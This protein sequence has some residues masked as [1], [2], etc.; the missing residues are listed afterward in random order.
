MKTTRP[1]LSGGMIAQVPLCEQ[2]RFSKLLPAAR[3]SS[4]RG[5]KTGTRF[6][7]I[8]KPSVVRYVIAKLACVVGSLL[9]IAPIALVRCRTYQKMS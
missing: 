7:E 1:A 3:E 6:A 4:L 5:K 2:E 9:R 8:A